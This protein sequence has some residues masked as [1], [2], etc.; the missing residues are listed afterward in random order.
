M[1]LARLEARYAASREQT[2]GD[3][4]LRELTLESLKRSINEFQEEI[5]RYNARHAVQADRT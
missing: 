4:E 1:K 2:G 3:E 5:A